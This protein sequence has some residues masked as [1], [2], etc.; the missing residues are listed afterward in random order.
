MLLQI[1]AEGMRAHG[2]PATAVSL[3]CGELTPKLFP[4]PD[5]IASFEGPF[6][7]LPCLHLRV[8]RSAVTTPRDLERIAEGSFGGE[9][10]GS[11]LEPGLTGAIEL[12][13]SRRIALTFYGRRRQ[14]A[15][16]A[17]CLMAVPMGDT[18][19][20]VIAGV[21]GTR[22]TRPTPQ[23]V[24]E[25]P[26]IAGLLETLELDTK[27]LGVFHPSALADNGA[28]PLSRAAT[29]LGYL[30]MFLDAPAEPAFANARSR[31]GAEVERVRQ[32]LVSLHGQGLVEAPDGWL[33]ETISGL[34]AL[35]DDDPAAL[36]VEAMLWS[37]VTR[38]VPE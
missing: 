35:P 2:L 6:G 32:A 5:T 20:L 3:D 22:R 1:T 29:G 37:V 4:A 34:P 38:L 27:A 9:L 8:V 10:I 14:G 13:G 16:V 7:G 28:G 23:D 21:L 33:A 11:N 24:M 30:C 36:Q 26:A 15:S 12:G 17:G 19:L 25:N 18:T 31:L